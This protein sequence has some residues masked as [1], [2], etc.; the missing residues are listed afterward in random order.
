MTNRVLICTLLFAQP[1]L[2]N[3]SSTLL[4]NKYAWCLPPQPRWISWAMHTDKST[5]RVLVMYMVG[6]FCIKL[7][8][9]YISP[10]EHLI[11]MTTTLTPIPFTQTLSSHLNELL[12]PPPNFSSWLQ[13]LLHDA[14]ILFFHI[15]NLIICSWL[16]SSTVM[17]LYIYLECG[18]STFQKSV[19]WLGSCIFL[20]VMCLL[21]LFSCDII[22]SEPHF[23]L[24]WCG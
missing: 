11:N 20:L 3:W 24:L 9:L 17:L 22:F 2:S 15:S 19:S 8:S 1:K 21:V 16:P 13:F 18:T 5:S 4:V 7:I 12:F 23:S 10:C 6:F 14:W